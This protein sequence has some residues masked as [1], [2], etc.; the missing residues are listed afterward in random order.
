MDS[1]ALDDTLPVPAADAPEGGAAQQLLWPA[2][3]LL[4]LVLLAGVLFFWWSARAPGEAS[5]EVTFARDMSAHH[6]QAVEMALIL[7]ARTADPNLQLFAQDM[8]LTQQAQIGQM[9]GWLQ[10]WQL[11]LAG[12]GPPMAGHG[13][14]MG[15]AV[16]EE[17]YALRELP[18]A[19]AETSFL[20]LMIRHHQGGLRM[21]QEVLAATPRPEVARLAQ[22]MIDGQQGEVT[23]M[24]ELLAARG[25]TPEL[26]AEESGAHQH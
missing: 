19:E 22:A 12:N 9:Q 23:Y 26:P 21:A 24:E 8:L 13:A 7:Q 3:S 4:L 6:A 1:A 10:A 25:R 11:P 5:A 18:V 20:Q 16:P 2:L 17:V 14:M 15:M